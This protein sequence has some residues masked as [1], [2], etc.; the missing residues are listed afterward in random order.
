[1][2]TGEWVDATRTLEATRPSIRGTITARLSASGQQSPVAVT[3]AVSP[4]GQ[5][6]ISDSTASTYVLS[7]GT[8]VD[9]TSPAK[10]VRIRSDGARS[11]LTPDDPIARVVRPD[12][13]VESS[14]GA[15]PQIV[16]EGRGSQSGRE[17]LTFT[18]SF[19]SGTK[20]TMTLDAATGVVLDLIVHDAAAQPKVA[21]QEFRVDDLDVNAPPLDNGAIS[22]PAGFTIQAVIDGRKVDAVVP[23][24]ATIASVVADV[25]AK[26]A[27]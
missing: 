6:A 3:F 8:V 11:V 23:P 18:I 7:D 16:F 17:T 25:R 1:V 9:V 4:D 12:L 15:G 21:D 5:L 27:R 22:L 19:A 20:W 14:T 26:A 2:S 13:W 10:T 24:N